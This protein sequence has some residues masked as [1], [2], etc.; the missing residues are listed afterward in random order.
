MK[1]RSARRL[2]AL[3]VLSVLAAAPSL[4]QVPR[5]A[6]DDPEARLT[7]DLG[8]TVAP[9]M[10]G[11]G[12][13]WWTV[14]RGRRAVR[15]LGVPYSFS[16]TQ[17]W[18]QRRLQIYLG[19][20]EALILPPVLSE[21]GLRRTSASAGSKLEPIT[22]ALAARLSQAAVKFGFPADRYAAL[23]ALSAGYQ[24]TS[25]FRASMGMRPEIL[26]LQVRDAARRQG[27]PAYNAAVIRTA[28]YGF[29]VEPAASTACLDGALEEVEKGAELS[30]AAVE[31]WAVGDVRTAL[32]APRGL[33]RCGFALRGQADLRRTLITAQ[34]EAITAALAGA[35]NQTRPDARQEAVAVVNLRSFLAEGGVLDQLRARGYE[36]TAPKD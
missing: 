1:P 5:P 21:D 16:S 18:S 10:V 15:V 19:D 3:C 29:V 4:A 30:R 31:A 32:T 14:R 11:S 25:D 33:E 22:P 36:V 24:V 35:R 27:V 17:D 8:V 23:D 12:P 13:A 9:L 28:S 2:A 20:A 6:I 34:V 26:A 7:A